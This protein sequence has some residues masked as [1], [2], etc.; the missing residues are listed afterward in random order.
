M[1][2]PWKSFSAR[3]SGGG[4]FAKAL[5]LASITVAP[6]SAG[7]ASASPSAPN[8]SRVASPSLEASSSRPSR[9]MP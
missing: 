7:S 4:T 9:G 5:A 6:P 8:S 1:S 2:P 3:G